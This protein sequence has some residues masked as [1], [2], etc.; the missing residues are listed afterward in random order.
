[1]PDLFEQL[2]GD[3]LTAKGYVCKFNV[4]YRKADG[5]Q[6]GSDIDVLAIR[7]K[8]P[9]D[10]IVGDCK[11]WVAG[12][13]PDWMTTEPIK[14]AK[15]KDRSYFKAIFEKQWTEGLE[16]KVLDEC[17]TNRFSYVVYCAR[18]GDSGRAFEALSI[19][20]NPIRVVP[21]AKMIHETEQRLAD[22]SKQT[23]SVEPTTLGRFVQ[24]M[25]HASIKFAFPVDPA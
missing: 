1:M 16:R 23:D 24:L 20:G 6:S 21:L 5:K 14:A 22:R 9:H 17:G 18:L 7:Q 8:R 4:N 3:Y 2:V 19:G 11:S 15:A 12:V 13:W 10:I 25:R